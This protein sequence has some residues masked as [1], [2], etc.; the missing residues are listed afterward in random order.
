VG[1]IKAPEWYEW[2]LQVQRELSNNLLLTVNYVG[3]SGKRLIYSNAWPNA[4]DEYGI[5][6]GVPG[7]PANVPVANYGI[8]T[9]YQN[10]AVSNYEGMST[11]VTKRFSNSMAFH[12]NYTWSHNIDECSNGCLFTDGSGDFTGGQ[13]NPLSLRANNYGNADYDIRSNFSGD[14]LVN[15]T[16]HGGNQV[17]KAVVNGWNLSGKIYWRTGMPFSVTDGNS[18][19]GNGGG[20]IY[21]TPFGKGWGGSSCGSANAFTGGSFTPC[22]NANVYLNSANIDVFNEWS[23]QTRNQ[24]RGPHFFDTDISLYRNFKIAEK[25]TFGV[26]AQAFNVFNH[27]NF[28]NPDA[29]LGDSTFGAI[30][31][32][33]NSPTSPYGTFLGFDSSVRVVQLTGKIV[34]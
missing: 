8:V 16:I 33:V 4:Y 2:N 24:L 12:F 10:G 31:G 13:I 30:T 14:F 6:P 7:I 29:G 26:G 21:A 34:F 11:T 3:N 23:P 20:S 22:I 18:A 27:P 1:T 25:A 28:A 19:L 17:L 5:Y 9:T 32:M 15:P